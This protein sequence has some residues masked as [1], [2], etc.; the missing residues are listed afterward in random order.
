MGGKR[1]FRL[2]V[3]RKNEERKKKLLKDRATDASS[4]SVTS[5]SVLPPPSDVDSSVQLHQNLLK[6]PLPPQWL[7]ISADPL[8]ICKMTV[9]TDKS[10]KASAS[11]SI[12][13][14]LE[15]TMYYLEHKLN[16]LNCP[17]LNVLPSRIKNVAMVKQMM[18]LID[19]SKLCIGNSDAKFIELFEQRKLTLHVSSGWYSYLLNT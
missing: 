15:W 9:Y 2:S 4:I 7:V 3:H 11:I 13:R 10:A 1:K 16:S 14:E 8:T 19:N 18:L 6:V 5:V 17:M 12:K